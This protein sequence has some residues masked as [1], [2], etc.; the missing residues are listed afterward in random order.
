MRNKAVIASALTIFLCA[1]ALAAGGGG[2]LSASSQSSEYRNAIK[3]VKKQDY[4]S[5]I[6]LLQQSLD[7]NPNNANAWNYMGYS[8]RNLQRYDEALA[9][10]EK[11]IKIKPKHKGAIEYLGE[12]YLQIDQLDK[13]KAQ[14]QRLDDVCFLSCKEYRQLKKK[15]Q[16]YEAG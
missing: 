11:A 7:K 8:L 10:Y 13:A 9:A 5:A 3:A 4:T 16:Q 14:L 2:G 6:E 12:L 1:N 15:I